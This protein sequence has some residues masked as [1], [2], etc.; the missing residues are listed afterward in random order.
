MIRIVIVEEMGL[1]RGALRAVLSGEDDLEVVADLPESGDVLAVIRTK[2]PDVVLVDVE[3]RGLDMLAT[4]QKLLVEAPRTAVL[5]LGAQDSPR[6]L[7]EA[8][9]AGVRGFVGKDLQPAELA[10]LLR[11]VAAG[12]V[13]LDPAAAVAALSPPENPLTRRE[14]E[15]LHVAAEGL[16]LKEIARRLYLAHGTVRNHLS[17]ILRKTGSRTRL[18]A[19]RRAQRAGWL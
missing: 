8:L 11:A 3:L 10:R 19:I 16:P 5:A 18:E 2:R 12:E 6:I 14:R 4:V 15:V 9:R 7:S 17:A 1:L 13:V